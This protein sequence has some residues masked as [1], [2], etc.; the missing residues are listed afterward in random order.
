VEAELLVQLLDIVAAKH[1]ET[2]FIKSV[3]TKCVENFQDRDCP[4][5]LFYCNGDLTGNLIP[6]ADVLGGKRMTVETIEFVLA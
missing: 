6:C 3:A 1:P 5:L 2:K 4:A